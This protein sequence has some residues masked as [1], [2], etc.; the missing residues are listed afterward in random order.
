MQPQGK[1][2]VQ[3]DEVDNGTCPECG[4]PRVAGMTCWEQL[5]AIGAWEWQDPEL[6]AQHFLTVAAYNLQHP[7]QFTDEAID[8]LRHHFIEHLDKGLPVAEIRRRVGQAVAGNV[9]V[10]KPATERRPVLRCW[11]MTIADVYLPDQP[12]GAAARVKAWAASI[13]EEFRS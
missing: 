5:G 3:Q 12:E 2:A 4:A 13:R 1:S 8:G 9:R 10:L 6:L 7:A 11:A